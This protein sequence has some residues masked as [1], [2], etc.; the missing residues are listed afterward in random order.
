MWLRTVPHCNHTVRLSNF[1]RFLSLT[2]GHFFLYIGVKQEMSRAI[3]L[4][5]RRK[6]VWI[7]V[8]LQTK[9]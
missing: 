2:P 7:I 5:Y 1:S 9:H 3:H 6:L 4:M 8:R